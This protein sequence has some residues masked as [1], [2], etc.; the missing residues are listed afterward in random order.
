MSYGFST[1]LMQVFPI[2]FQGHIRVYAY[3]SSYKMHQT[4]QKSRRSE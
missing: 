3:S 2:K 4:E 1:R